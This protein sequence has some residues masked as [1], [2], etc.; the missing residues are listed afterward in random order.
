MQLALP[1]KKFYR[2]YYS[3]SGV[4]KTFLASDSLLFAEGRSVGTRVARLPLS[5]TA[6]MTFFSLPI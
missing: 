2:F 6:A 1:G 4:R 5:R 3:C